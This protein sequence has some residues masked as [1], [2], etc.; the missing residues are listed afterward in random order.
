MCQNV[1]VQWEYFAVA[2]LLVLGAPLPESRSSGSVVTTAV[3]LPVLF[4]MIRQRMWLPL[5]V[6]RHTPKMVLLQ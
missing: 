5:S 6:P 3:V 2:G 1:V 4:S